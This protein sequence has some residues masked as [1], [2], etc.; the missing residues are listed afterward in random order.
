MKRFLFSFLLLLSAAWASAQTNINA[1]FV[2][3]PDSLLPL[4]T[5]NDRLDLLDYH[6]AGMEARVTN[7]MGGTTTLLER[8]DT[9]ICLQLTVVSRW[10]ITIVT[11]TFGAV[12]YRITKTFFLPEEWQ[13]E[14]W[15]DPE[16]EQDKHNPNKTLSEPPALMANSIPA[17]RHAPQHPPYS[18]PLA[19]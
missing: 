19:D 12:R 14:E 3:V 15:Y 9:T 5:R 6:K 1:V 18:R 10:R 13:R 17:P 7:L 4:L 8:N 16:S 2:Y 11:D